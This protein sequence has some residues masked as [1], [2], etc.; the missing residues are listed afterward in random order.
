VEA[1]GPYALGSYA[2]NQKQ[3]RRAHG[4]FS[5]A[6]LKA[7]ADVKLER[8]KE[9]YS[10]A[11]PPRFRPTRPNAPGAV[12]CLGAVGAADGSAQALTGVCLQCSVVGLQVPGVL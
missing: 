8:V 2:N 4:T 9:L 6:D 12:L 5:T 10:P 1:E 11:P 3:R 7:E